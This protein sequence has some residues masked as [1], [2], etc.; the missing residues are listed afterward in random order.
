MY[1][2]L[3]LCLMAS[4]V[5]MIP[6]GDIV[7]TGEGIRSAVGTKTEKALVTKVSSDAIELQ[8]K[9]TNGKTDIYSQPLA[10]QH[11]HV[12]RWQ[13]PKVAVG[14]EVIKGELIARG[15]TRIFF[16][17]EYPV[18]TLIVFIL[19][20]SM[21]IGSSAIYRH[22]PDYFP[23]EVGI[24]GGLV[25][26]LG[27]LGGF[28]CPKIFGMLLQWTGVWTTSWMFLAVLTIICLV[29]MHLVIK[30]MMIPRSPQ[31][32]SSIEEK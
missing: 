20:M 12:K 3:S 1:G 18:F 10:A 5:L 25:G 6:K 14:V 7:T 17:I 8:Y 30:H 13:E 22:I 26:V 9:R 27:G 21:G 4:A 28:F 15:F 32:A 31:L 19:G 29:W 16:E 2:A 23:N 24:V 11:D